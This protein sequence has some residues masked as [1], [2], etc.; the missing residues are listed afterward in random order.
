MIQSRIRLSLLCLLSFTF[1]G[2]LPGS[3]AETKHWAYLKPACPKFPE[4]RNQSWPR[5]GIDYFVLARLEKER[6]SPSAQAENAVLFR[7]LNLDLTGL[8]PA[9][10]EVDQFVRDES[11]DA[12]DKAVDRLL[13]SPHY[14]EHWARMWLDLARYADSHGYEKD[15]GRQMWLYRD[16]VID[17]L[18]QNMKFD[19]FTIEQLAGDLLPG[20]TVKQKI[21]SGFHRNTMFNTEGGV[22]KEEARVETIVDR[23]NTT[24]SVWLGSTLACAQCHNHKYD[25]FTMKDYY[26]FFAF[27]N[28][29]DEP[30]LD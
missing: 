25:P 24:A 20:A 23:V 21:A 14:G 26:Q 6:L 9:V 4:V 12:W 3:G 30:A 27:F 28:T 1:Y 18:N 19:Q 17:A 10:S 29:V 16:W 8:P 2:T 15:P 7:R 5:N 22:D 11:P 13:S